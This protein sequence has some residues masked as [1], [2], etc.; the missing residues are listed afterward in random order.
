M[1]SKDILSNSNVKKPLVCALCKSEYITNAPI[2]EKCQHELISSINSQRYNEILAKNFELTL[3][4]IEQ[5]TISLDKSISNSEQQILRYYDKIRQEINAR[6]VSMIQ[7]IE[8]EKRQLFQVIDSNQKDCLK[9]Y[10]DCELYRNDLV[11][12]I[13]EADDFVNI[14]RHKSAGESVL[15]A[16]KKGYLFKI[17]LE[18]K[19]VHYESF[20]FNKRLSF[21]LIVEKD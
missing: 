2:T 8:S 16:F 1:N 12:F 20:I 19:K 17:E 13:K 3:A 5:N 14:W 6:V 15:D 21:I 4:K 18:R 7:E 9:N 10:K 11:G